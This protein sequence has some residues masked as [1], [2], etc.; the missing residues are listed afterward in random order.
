MNQP[1]IEA[2]NLWKQYYRHDALEG[3]SF[4]VQ[5][6]TIYGLLGPNGAGKTTTIQILMN[7]ITPS[8]GHAEVLG[9]QASRLG[10]RDFRRIGY[11]SENQRLPEEMSVGELLD[12]L[13]PYYPT[14]DDTLCQELLKQLELPAGRKVRHLSRGMKMKAALAASLAFRPELLVLDEP[15]S[16]LDPVVREDF[17]RGLLGTVA[18]SNGTVFMSSQDVEE[19]ER[20]CDW[21]G[22]MKPG[23]LII[24]EPLDHLLRRFRKI[25][26][27]APGVKALDTG[28]GDD[29]LDASPMGEAVS[30][31]H[32]RFEGA[33]T[34]GNLRARVPAIKSTED[35]P[36][37]LRE[38]YLAL[39]RNRT[40]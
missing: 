8:A 39:S 2:K 26:I 4:R 28:W 5:S 33:E 7:L 21:V 35:F 12:Y 25:E 32:T 13:K 29:V 15:F 14:W 23:K 3:V 27:T 17:T 20:L 40:R 18:D 19:V 10:W 37:T 16:G 36:M 6:G 9:R 31:V 22:I 11:V 24:S 30:L 38:I 1:A 34:I